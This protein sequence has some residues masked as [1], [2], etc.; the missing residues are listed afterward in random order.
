MAKLTP[1]L[2]AALKQ[3]NAGAA[4]MQREAGGDYAVALSASKAGQASLSNVVGR[5]ERNALGTELRLQTGLRASVRS[6]KASARNTR[7]TQNR[8]ENL[9]GVSGGN[10]FRN[11]RAAAG[12]GKVVAKGAAAAGA[13]Q[14][15]T[16][17]TVMSI[18]NAGVAAQ[19]SA[20]EYS[21]NQ[22]LMARNAANAA[23]TA[24]ETHDIMMQQA[25]FDQQKAMA[26]YQFDLQQKALKD[27]EKKS[28]SQ[29]GL[30]TAVNASW[31]DAHGLMQAWS[32]MGAVGPG[33]VA[34]AY[35]QKEGI[36][37]PNEQALVVAIARQLGA[38]VDPASLEHMYDPATGQYN[39]SDAQLAIDVKAA[40]NNSLMTLYPHFQP[41]FAAI[42]GAG[43][44]AI[45]TNALAGTQP[46]GNPSSSP[47]IPGAGDAYG[48][49]GPG[50]PGRL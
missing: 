15:S 38:K 24:S 44:A 50:I 1:G 23:Q 32:T 7:A 12:A 17:K 36:T 30:Q 4:A 37:D 25:A 19:G 20:A 41:S 33:Q 49:R 34:A 31:D 48:G 18:A 29:Q 47:A 5:L 40:V 45:T 13:G 10:S 3:V 9:Y 43:D 46:M 26:K 42:N 11:A 39:Y 14:L 8:A 16:A 6:A 35:I 27:A 2:R 22:A 28:H 21:L